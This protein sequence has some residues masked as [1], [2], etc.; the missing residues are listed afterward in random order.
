MGLLGKIFDLQTVKYR[1]ALQRRITDELLFDM[2]TIGIGPAVILGHTLAT[3]LVVQDAVMAGHTRFL[4]LGGKEVGDEDPIFTRFLVENLGK[5]GLPLPSDPKMKECQYAMEV[6]SKH[7]NIPSG[8]IIY[9]AGDLST[10]LQQNL[11]TMGVGYGRLD[12]LEFYTLASTARRVIGTARKVFGNY[13]AVISAHNVYPA[14]FNRDNWMHDPASRFYA[15]SEAEKVLSSKGPSEYEK[16][17]FCR[18]VNIAYEVAR[19]HAYN[20]R[21]ER[22]AMPRTDGPA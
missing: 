5:A 2:P 1:P 22:R 11:E 18:P 17:G 20:E 6:L 15:I 13:D 16:R 3:A 8:R 9:K 21:Q 4:V 19:V 14:G 10:N 7:F 12:S